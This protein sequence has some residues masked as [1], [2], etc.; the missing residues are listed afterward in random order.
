VKIAILTNAYPYHPGEQFMEDEIAFW[1][2]NPVA[3]VTLLPAVAAGEPRPL[4]AGIAVDL[5]MAGGSR[6]ARLRCVLRAAGSQL[7]R[8]ELAYLW[9]SRKLRVATAL[10]AILHT[11]KVLEQQQRLERYARTHGRI[12]VAYCYWNETQSYAALRARA[13]GAVR[14]VVSRLHGFDLYEA[15]REHAYMPL[16]R[17][18]IGCFDTLFA[19]S[20]EARTYLEATY[21]APAGNTRISPLGVPLTGALSAASPPGFLHLVSVSSCLPVKRLDR[22]VEAL[23]LLARRHAQARIT[24]THIGGGPQLAEIAQLAQTRLGGLSNVAFEFLGDLPNQVVKHYYLGTPVDVFVNT[25][26]SE[27]MPVSVMEAM[28]AGVPAVAPD[29]GGV[30]D[31]VSDECGALLAASPGSGEIADAIARVALGGEKDALRLQAR[32]VIEARFCA[33]RNYPAFIAGVLAIGAAP[34]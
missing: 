32:R 30:S 2:G 5:G 1:A 7:F 23:H 34:A 22:I 27:G 16:K 19:L 21:G 11:S 28:S 15:R 14:K 13:A 17:Q 4:P 6:L 10:R 20:R 33:G 25:S 12:D 9:G 8:R 31:L 24:W 26:E 29:V 3:E 18:F